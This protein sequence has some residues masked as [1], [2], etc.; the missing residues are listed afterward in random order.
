MNYSY[1]EITAEYRRLGYSYPADSD[2]T[3]EQIAQE[4]N[5]LPAYAR[6]TEI[7]TLSTGDELKPA[8]LRAFA[9]LADALGYPVTD[10][11]GK[12]AVKRELSD[13]QKRETALSHLKLR[14][15]QELRDTA[16][17]SLK[18]EAAVTESL[19]QIAASDLGKS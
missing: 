2:F 13:E 14:R 16:E 1:D 12:L 18:H 5:H 6:Y 17:A 4:A 15:N 7:A 3:E 11:C 9:E 10:E 8:A 19:R